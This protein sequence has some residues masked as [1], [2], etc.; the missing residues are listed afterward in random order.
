MLKCVCK[1]PLPCILTPTH[2]HTTHTHTTHT[3]HSHTPHTLSHTPH[4]HTHTGSK[5]SPKPFK[6][7]D[8]KKGKGGNQ[9][10]EVCGSVAIAHYIIII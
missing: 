4:S 10:D 5:F 2:T 3:P 7:N 1:I 9:S 8:K 6:K